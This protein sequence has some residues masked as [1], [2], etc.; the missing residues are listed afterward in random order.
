MDPSHLTRIVTSWEARLEKDQ[1][2]RSQMRDAEG[3]GLF[4][5][6][7]GKIGPDPTSEEQAKRGAEPLFLAPADAQ[8]QYSSERLDRTNGGKGYTRGE[9]AELRVGHRSFS[10]WEK[11]EAYLA[12]PS[13]WLT[14]RVDHQPILEPTRQKASY[15]ADCCRDI[16]ALGREVE[17]YREKLEAHLSG[18]EAEIRTHLWVTEDFTDPAK[19]SLEGTRRTVEALLARI[20]KVRIPAHVGARS[21]GIWAGVPEHSGTIG[22]KRRGRGSGVRLLTVGLGVSL[23]LA[24]GWPLQ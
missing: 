1:A 8:H 10:Y 2:S 7:S 5:H 14:R 23:D 9:L 13:S 21:G 11:R 22:A 18:L 12:S 24:D 4:C 19:R 15:I 3:R 16:I 20:A 6:P 17:S